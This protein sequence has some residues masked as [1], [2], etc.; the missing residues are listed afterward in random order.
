MFPAIPFLRATAATERKNGNGTTAKPQW[1][2]GN[3]TLETRR[4]SVKMS[5][6]FKQQCSLG[7][8]INIYIKSCCCRQ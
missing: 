3:G 1:Q 5:V 6:H 8:I 4:N 7:A 2:N